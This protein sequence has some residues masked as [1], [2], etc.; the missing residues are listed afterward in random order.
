MKHT[1]VI[2]L[3]SHVKRQIQ[4][5]LKMLEKI[6]LDLKEMLDNEIQVNCYSNIIGGLI[7]QFIFDLETKSSLLD[8]QTMRNKSDKKK[9]TKIINSNCYGYV[10]SK[11][12][13]AGMR[14]VKSKIAQLVNN[15]L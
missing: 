2:L 10:E 9:R 12:L 3:R 6:Y 13:C 15:N 7:G 1:L 8:I 11:A 4:C 14:L 5:G